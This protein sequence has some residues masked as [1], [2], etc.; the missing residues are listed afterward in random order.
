MLRNLVWKKD[1]FCPRNIERLTFNSGRGKI[2]TRYQFF[3]RKNIIV[4][5]N[6][7]IQRTCDQFVFVFVSF[8]FCFLFYFKPEIIYQESNKWKIYK[9]I[10]NT[11]NWVALNKNISHINVSSNHLYFLNIKISFLYVYHINYKLQLHA[12]SLLQIRQVHC[13]KVC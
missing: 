13:L 9:M 6:I 4:C 7:R 8:L 2:H 12:K 10:F 1:S 5:I 11:I 3:S